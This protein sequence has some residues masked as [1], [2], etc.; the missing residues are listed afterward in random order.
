[1]VSSVRSLLQ[2]GSLQLAEALAMFF[3]DKLQLL[4]LLRQDDVKTY[5]AADKATGQD[6][7][8]HWLPPDGSPQLARVMS[9]LDGLDEDA[10]PL[11]IEVGRRYGRG[12][13]ITQNPPTFI[14]LES[15]LH[16]VKDFLGTTSLEKKGTW[17]IPSEFIGPKSPAS[18]APTL[19]DPGEFTRLMQGASAAEPMQQEP[20]APHPAPPQPGD[21]T[22]FMRQVQPAPPL[23]E[24]PA[25]AGE[26]TRL[27]Q[28]KPAPA[29][30]QPERVMRP[31]PRQE[32]GEFTRLF[33][34]SAASDSHNRTPRKPAGEGLPEQAQP[35]EFTRLFRLPATQPTPPLKDPLSQPY[36]PGEFSSDVS[37]NSS[38]SQGATQVF[39]R[40]SVQPAPAPQRADGPG[41]YTRMFG[42]PADASPVDVPSAPL[43]AQPGEFTRLFQLPT[44]QPMPLLPR[45]DPFSQPYSPGESSSDFSRD[46]G[47]QAGNA[48][49]RSSS[50]SQGATQVF[51]RPAVQAAAVPRPPEGPGEY[52]RMFGTPA[53]AP[54]VATPSAPPPAAAPAPAVK[55][56]TEP[57][58]WIFLAA[59]ALLA[60][61][62]II[63][64]VYFALKK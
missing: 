3:F 35:G 5:R 46:F 22:R 11:I 59:L 43:Q 2:N 38:S 32:A 51:A 27:M 12:Y 26:F 61:C 47:S 34:P 20:V 64:I 19:G 18:D 45:E 44:T 52:T 7:L 37:R 28:A 55:K 40:P 8:L 53:I 50:S 6:Y 9:L 25:P 10:R 62:A 33:A 42:T 36:S 4:E 16:A 17:K 15:W 60:V 56:K 29:P 49:D 54:L 1:M 63:L 58:L 13:L 30:A 39:A 21:F 24:P 57:A 23:S 48:P 31:V 14:G 41:E